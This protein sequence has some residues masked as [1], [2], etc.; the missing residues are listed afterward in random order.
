MKQ[1]TKLPEDFLRWLDKGTTEE[2]SAGGE[3]PI[4]IIR[5]DFLTKP[6]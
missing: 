5:I 4:D 2:F 1:W 6:K 3:F